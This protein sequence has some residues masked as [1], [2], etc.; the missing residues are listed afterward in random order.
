LW[1][2]EMVNEEW[3][4][5]YAMSQHKYCL[6]SSCNKYSSHFEKVR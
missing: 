2:I 5:W 4:T 3:Y 1:N 6:Y